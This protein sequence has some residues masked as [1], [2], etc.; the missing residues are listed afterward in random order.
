VL[1]IIQRLPTTKKQSAA[2]AKGI[3][4][5]RDSFA[6]PDS[7]NSEPRNPRRKYPKM[8]LL[9]RRSFLVSV[10]N[11]NMHRKSEIRKYIS[12]M[13]ARVMRISAKGTPE[14]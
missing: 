7:T 11:K 9:A 14:E 6:A 3:E 13:L 10:L 1:V 2:R 8:G 5:C 4:Y 12:A